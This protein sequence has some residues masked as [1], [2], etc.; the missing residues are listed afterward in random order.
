GREVGHTERGGLQ[1][2]RDGEVRVVLDLERPRDPL[3]ERPA[4]A[5][6]RAVLDVADPGRHHP[7]G[8]AGRDELVEADV[9][10]GADEREVAAALADQLVG[11]GEGNEA[12]QRGAQGH[13]T[14]IR[15]VPAHRLDQR[16]DLAHFGDFTQ[17][18]RTPH[19]ILR[20]TMWRDVTMALPFALPGLLAWWW[21]RALVRRGDDG[22]LPER[23]AEYRSHLTVAVAVVA[24]SQGFLGSP[25][26]TWGY[27]LMLLGILAGGFPA[28]RALFGE[29]W[30]FGAYLSQT[31]RLGLGVPGFWVLLIGAPGRVPAGAP[32]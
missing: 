19:A 2:Q 30:H 17:S 18:A 20:A 29:T 21:G 32:P 4:E 6:A 10:D 28:R 24:V 8:A 14:P 9:G 27:L 25:W 5:V 3:L 13:D 26:G 12:L 1:R 15:D 16:Q 22:A 11:G 31:V 7:A 23:L